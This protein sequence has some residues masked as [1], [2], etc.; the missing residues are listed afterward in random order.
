MTLITTV[1]SARTVEIQ[2]EVGPLTVQRAALTVA[3]TQLARDESCS[4]TVSVHGRL[5][6]GF[7]SSVRLDESDINQ[8]LSSM[9]AVAS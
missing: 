7:R 5:P 6:G 4:T 2:T 1:V 9:R 8:L 3:L